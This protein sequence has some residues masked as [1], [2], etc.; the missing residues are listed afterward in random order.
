MNK[1]EEDFEKAEDKEAFRQK[2]W[3][4]LKELQASKAL[5]SEL[6]RRRAKI[7]NL[8]S[9][10]ET[11]ERKKTIQELEIE[12]TEKIRAFLKRDIGA[13]G[14]KDSIWSGLLGTTAEVNAVQAEVSRL[15]NAG[16]LTQSGK[17]SR[18]IEIGRDKEVALTDYEYSSYVD[19]IAVVVREAA[20]R[21][22]DHPEW[23]GLTDKR[24]AFVIKKAI[25]RGR[26]QVRRQLKRTL[27]NR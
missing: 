22:M 11:S 27:R 23:E 20:S 5:Q 15:V 16:A 14:S 7:N 13:T 26:K 19:D 18:T 8:K 21:T 17:P 12:R 24:K 9:L 6:N 25:S 10:E 2:H 4:E 3:K 1:V